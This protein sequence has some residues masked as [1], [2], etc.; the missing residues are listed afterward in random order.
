MCREVESLSLCLR[1]QCH[2]T[3]HCEILLRT[4]RS[5]P[6]GHVLT[7]MVEVKQTQPLLLYYL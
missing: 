6:R 7:C 1:G 5:E 4:V 3:M 2:C